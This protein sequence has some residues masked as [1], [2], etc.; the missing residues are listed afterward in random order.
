MN[1]QCYY[2]QKL[3]PLKFYSG[4]V[5]IPT[6]YSIT[7][8]WNTTTI[9]KGESV[10]ITMKIKATEDNKHVLIQVDD[11]DDFCLCGY[12]LRK[13]KLEV[14]EEL[15]ITYKFISLHAGICAVPSPTFMRNDAELHVDFENTIPS[16]TVLHSSDY[17]DIAI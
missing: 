17:F 14:G 16:I 5:K 2:K 1:I 9:I 15:E 10:I 7:Y 4:I 12:S 3:Y 8:H 13:I 6:F 11:N